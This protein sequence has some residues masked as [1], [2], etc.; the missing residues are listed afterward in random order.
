MKS[1][2]IR[3]WVCKTIYLAYLNKSL[4]VNCIT[5]SNCL[6]VLTKLLA[7]FL[8][9]CIVTFRVHWFTQERNLGGW[10][11]KPTTSSFSFHQIFIEGNHLQCQ[12]WRIL[13]LHEIDLHSHWTQ[14][15]LYLIRR[16]FLWRYSCMIRMNIPSAYAGRIVLQITLLAQ[17]WNV[18]I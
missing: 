4:G 6:L 7:V 15:G 5:T 8:L 14:I 13:M 16:D 9:E 17:L 12:S 1:P 18:Y 2:V 10:G 3:V 11:G